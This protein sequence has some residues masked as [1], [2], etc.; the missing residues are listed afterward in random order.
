[1]NTGTSAAAP[2]A[3]AV[4]AIV[5]QNDPSLTPPEIYAILES[6]AD[7]MGSLGFDFA[8]GYGLIDTFRAIGEQQPSNSPSALVTSSPTLSPSLMPSRRPIIDQEEKD[9]TLFDSILGFVLKILGAIMDFI[10][11]WI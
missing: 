9:P 11:G 7:D 1:M 3:A 8:S 6:S 2:H 4:A 10:F 5:L